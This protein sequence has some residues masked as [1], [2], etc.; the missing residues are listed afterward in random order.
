MRFK[1]R[2]K[3]GAKMKEPTVQSVK[4]SIHFMCVPPLNMN[5]RV[6][7]L[8]P[9]RE[10]RWTCGNMSKVCMSLIGLICLVAPEPMKAG[11]RQNG[12]DHSISRTCP[13]FQGVQIWPQF[14]PGH[15]RY[16]LDLEH[17]QRRNFQPLRDGLL[18]DV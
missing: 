10:N 6:P 5:G 1:K 4:T 11:E 14:M 13:I 16:A 9:L 12:E 7:Q 8:Q 2:P 17:T 18:S 15:A 3:N